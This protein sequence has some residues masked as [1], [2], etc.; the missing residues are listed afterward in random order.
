MKNTGINDILLP[1][2]NLT[3]TEHKAITIKGVDVVND[4]SCV[5]L[6]KLS[7]GFPRRLSGEY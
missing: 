5:E 3:C 6:S 2:K 4:P 7:L 1:S